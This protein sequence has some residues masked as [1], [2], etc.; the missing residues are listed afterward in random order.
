MST[1][2]FEEFTPWYRTGVSKMELVAFKIP[3]ALREKMAETDLVK[4]DGE[5]QFIREAIREKL[6]ALGYVVE[7]SL[8]FRASR[9]GVGGR[10]THR[11][12]QTAAIEVNSLNGSNGG[13][14]KKKLKKLNLDDPKDVDIILKAS[15]VAAGLTP[16]LR[17]PPSSTVVLPSDSASSPTGSNPAEKARAK[18]LPK[19]APKQ[20]FSGHPKQRSSP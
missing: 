19:Q 2:L 17:P 14:Q 13:A 1:F 9:K 8:T 18:A 11:A 7:D 10:P 4:R 12:V 3:L 15:L 6:M 16:P 5:G 20:P